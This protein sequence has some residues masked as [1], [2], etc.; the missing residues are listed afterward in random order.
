[1]EWQNWL[2]GNG[3][4]SLIEDNVSARFFPTIFSQ[5]ACALKEKDLRI[6]VLCLEED[7]TTLQ[8]NLGLS[9]TTAFVNGA[10]LLSEHCFLNDNAELSLVLHKIADR[11][12]KLQ[13]DLLLIDS[14]VPLCYAASSGTLDDQTVLMSVISTF[15]NPSHALAIVYHQDALGLSLL[16]ACRHVCR[17]SLI[18]DAGTTEEHSLHPH[19]LTFAT[20]V[21]VGRSD[22]SSTFCRGVLSL[23]PTA[24]WTLLHKQLG[25]K[26]RITSRGTRHQLDHT[27]DAKDSDRGDNESSGALPPRRMERQACLSTFAIGWPMGPR[28]AWW[29]HYRNRVGLPHR[30]H[31]LAFQA[32]QKDQDKSVFRADAILS[33]DMYDDFMDEYEATA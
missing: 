30:R 28:D 22:V 26:G 4:C 31:T 33:A 23:T 10:D 8:S 19:A 27:D 14:L 11:L 1:M 17:T 5:M 9:L 18:L 12:A 20:L 3:E 24:G 2:T 21:R 15:Q 25:E 32:V 6:C 13:Y 16:E 29:G 7:T